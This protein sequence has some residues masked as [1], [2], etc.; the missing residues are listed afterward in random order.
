MVCKE[1]ERRYEQI[2]DRLQRVCKELYKE[3]EKSVVIEWSKEDIK[4]GF[5]A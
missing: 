5:K 1:C 4:A 3:E 2:L